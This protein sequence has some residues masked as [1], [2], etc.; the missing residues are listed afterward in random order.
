MMRQE[1]SSSENNRTP[2]SKPS[3]GR[4]P[5]SKKY[6]IISI[7]GTG[8]VV[9]VVVIV[10]GVTLGGGEKTLDPQRLPGTTRA[11]C[12]LYCSEHWKLVEMKCFSLSS[13]TRDWD[14]SQENC[15]GHKATLAVVSQKQLEILTKGVGNSDY[16]I[17]LKKKF[18]Q[19][20]WDDNT[21]FNKEFN[22]RGAGNCAY[23]DSSSVNSAGC[24]Q[25]RRWICS[26]N[27]TC[28]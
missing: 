20:K 8:V 5:L 15:K 28:L 22:I 6:T 17:G 2:S 24:S 21:T 25:P 26:R 27:L 3:S 23:L 14:S 12:Q 19:W 16:W 13:E 9:V 11:P 4:W 18:D 10:L 1:G 7:G